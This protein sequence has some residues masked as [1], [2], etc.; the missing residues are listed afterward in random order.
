MLWKWRKYGQNSLSLM[1]LIEFN[2]YKKYVGQ[3]LDNLA[4]SIYFVLLHQTM[5][6]LYGMQVEV[7]EHCTK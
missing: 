1:F 7:S 4:Y 2:T 5:Y 6:L 3:K